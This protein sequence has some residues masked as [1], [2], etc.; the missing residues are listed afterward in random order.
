MSNETREV[1]LGMLKE[2]TGRHF[3]DSGGAYGRAWE[4]NQSRDLGN[5]PAS[6]LSFRYKEVDLTH[7]T[8]HWLAER[9]DYAPD[10]QEKFDAYV[11]SQNDRDPWLV[12]M[13]GFFDH[14][15][16][17]GHEVRDPIDRRD[18]TPMI[19]NTYNYEC[20]LDQTLQFAYATVD[21]D[22]VVLLQIHGGCDVRGGY[23]APKVFR[24]SG[25]SD[26]AMLDYGRGGI[27]CDKCDANWMLDGGYYLYDGGAR[28][29]KL[30]PI[31]PHGEQHG[32]ATIERPTKG[33]VYVDEEGHG[34]CPVCGEGRLHGGF[35]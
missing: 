9:L 16:A 17:E 19:V 20:L 29:P 4:R 30:D 27:G 6:T 1:L 14:L 24:E 28:G 8:F 11:E 2:N 21:G 10:L 31:V 13:E 32:E 22:P 3:L 33:L 26:Y 15:S 35:F 34:Y 25:H 12:L 5:E 23:T 18:G 7:S